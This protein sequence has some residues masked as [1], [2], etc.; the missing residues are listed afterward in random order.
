VLGPA[1]DTYTGT[2]KTKTIQDVRTPGFH[3]ILQCGGFLPLNPVVI[4]T[5]EETRIAGSVGYTKHSKQSGVWYDST[6]QSGQRS[7]WKF[8]GFVLQVPAYDEAKIAYVSNAAIADA[9]AAI[10]DALTSMAEAQ[11]SAALLADTARGLISFARGLA[12]KAPRRERELKADW[13]RQKWLE[14]R[15]GWR[16]LVME[17]ED[18]M[19]AFN[20]KVAAGEMVK[21]RASIGESLN[22]SSSATVDGSEAWITTTETLE[23]HRT[24]RAAAYAKVYNA[25]LA[26][27]GLDPI[28]TGWEVLTFSF[29]VDWFLDINSWLQ[30]WSPFSGSQLL[31]CCA[32]VKDEYQVDH[33]RHVEWGRDASPT[34]AWT[35][36]EWTATTKLVVERYERFPSGVSLPHLN[37]RLTPARILDFAAILLG[38]R[39]DVNRLL[40]D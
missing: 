26:R 13:F 34:L 14:Y 27:F 28:V 22:D 9:K 16:P 39:S 2:V 10:W 25:D 38:G 36:G 8:D 33:E 30:A 6:Y 12:R 3:R 19:A 37:V 23:G 32:S 29:I 1:T 20:R 7:Q 5:V 31:A 21:G 15:Y 24:Y 11:K 40:R 18:I 17:A 35:E 4:E